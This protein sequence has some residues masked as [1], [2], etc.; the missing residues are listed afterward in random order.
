MRGALLSAGLGLALAACASAPPAASG[1]EALKGCWIEKTADGART[2]RWFEYAGA[3][4]GE[5]VYY[6]DDIPPQAAELNLELDGGDARICRAF[7]G[8]AIS[9]T[10]APAFFGRPAR[11]PGGD[12]SEIYASAE[13]LLMIGRSGSRSTTIFDGARDGCD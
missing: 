3:W 7:D 1:P 12:Y 10:C 9:S 6:S 8:L 5:A 4:R 13:R 11:P 2:M